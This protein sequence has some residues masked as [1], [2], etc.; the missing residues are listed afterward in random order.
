M[1]RTLGGVTL[2]DTLIKFLESGMAMRILIAGAT[3]AIGRPLIRYLK[4]NGH[5]KM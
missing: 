3:G 2:V 5:S 1:T 4:E